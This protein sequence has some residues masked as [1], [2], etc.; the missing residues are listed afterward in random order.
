MIVDGSVSLNA[1]AAGLD[2]PVYAWSIKEG[3]SV[4]I[5]EG[6][7]KETVTL[8]G[9]KEGTSIVTVTVTGD[10]G[11]AS[12]DYTVTVKKESEAQPT[13]ESIEISGPA[14]TE[15]TQGEDLDL[16]GL[17][18]TA[19][20]SDGKKV[21]VASGDYTVSGYDSKALGEQ[22]IT[23]TY[24][25]KTATFKVIVKEAAQPQPTLDRIELSGDVKTEYVKGEMLDL[26]KLTVTAVYSDGK[27][28]TIPAGN[29]T[30]SGYDS[31]KV[32]EQTVTV[33]YG[34]KT[35]SFKVTVKEKAADPSK[36]SDTQKPSGSQGADDTNK[37]VQTGDNTNLFLPIAGV[38]AAAAAVGVVLWRRKR[39]QK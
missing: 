35:A 34:G 31:S 15:Y 38:V 27:T 28:A 32:G 22:T 14:K 17:T 30:V 20:Y 19:V 3:D 1:L 26:S 2:N 8:K 23:V 25:N 6:A 33:T 24:E 7:D 4:E 5:A 12:A 37:A 36:P 13:L 21:Q 18:V 11:S 39:V 16:S 9:L 29:Y 10:N